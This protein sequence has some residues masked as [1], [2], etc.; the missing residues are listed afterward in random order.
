MCQAEERHDLIE[1]LQGQLLLRGAQT[2]QEQEW[3]PGDQLRD[4]YTSWDQGREGEVDSFSDMS[5]KEQAFLRH[6]W[7]QW[8]E[9][10][11]EEYPLTLTM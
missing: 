6:G 8:S 9:S 10:V 5:S 3:E 1:I 2:R 7:E 11:N 4:C